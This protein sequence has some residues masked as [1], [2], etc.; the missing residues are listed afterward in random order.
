MSGLRTVGFVGLGAMGAPLAMNV[1]RAG[2]E[3]LVHARRRQQADELLAA[4][5]QWRG[6]AG[7]LAAEADLVVTMLGGPADV[8]ALYRVELLPRAK[9]GALLVDM[10]TSSPRLAGALAAEGAQRGALVLDAP[11][12]GGRAG[13]RE[14]GLAIMVGGE[15]AALEAAHP[16]LAAMGRRIAWCG[17]AGSGQRAKLVNQVIVAGTL[18]GLVEGMALGREAGLDGSTLLPLLAEGSAGGFLY[19]AYAQKL[20]EGDMSPGFSVR[21]FV[22][23]LE[24]ALAEGES[25]GLDLA[26]TRLALERYRELERRAG[27]EAGIQALIALYRPA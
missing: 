10:T 22:K 1:L 9:A 20:L 3:L 5:A 8:G 7:A 4:G 19:R 13:A 23:D 26:A 2:F 15:P 24:L 12:T 6:A 21:H 16:V 14:A 27:P 18:L 11:V 25:L 17:P